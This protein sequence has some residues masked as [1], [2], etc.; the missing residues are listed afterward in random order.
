MA[1]TSSRVRIPH[2][3]PDYTKGLLVLQVHL[4]QIYTHPTM[5]EPPVKRNVIYY[6][7]ADISTF[8][9]IYISFLSMVWLIYKLTDS[10]ADLGIMGLT[11]HGPF[12]FSLFG[13]VIADNF[14][15]RKTVLRFNIAFAI[16]A[17][18]VLITFISGFLSLPLIFIFSF[19]LG[20]ILSIYYPSMIA[21]VRD[22]VTDKKEFPKI[23]GAAATNAKTGQ[24]IASSS[25]SFIIPAFTAAGTFL[26]ALFFNIAS[27]I[28]ISRIKYPDI[29]IQKKDESVL[30]QV[31][32]GLQYVLKHKPLIGI[33]LMMSMTSLAFIFVTFQMPLIDKEFLGGGSSNLGVLFIG[34][35]IGGLTSGIYLGRRKSTKN[36]LWFLVICV[37]FSGISI[38]GL[39][40]SRELWLSFIFAMGVDFSFIAALGMSNTLLQLLSKSEISGRVLG[41]NNMVSLGFFAVITMLLSFLAKSVGMETVMIGIG[42]SLLISV[43][44]YVA[45]L[46]LQRPILNRIYT[47]RDI[48]PEKQPI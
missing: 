21:M 36:L 2:S 45:S 19:L 37:A 29:P 43:I 20:T 23:M 46:K 9:S 13:G 4:S 38:T 33:I 22:I 28:S 12:L 42:I 18:I 6:F 15:R 11:L 27:I 31:K 30:K 47:E 17:A 16:L 39:S 40:L 35:A 41:I 8:T 10:S 24:L 7:I 26:L 5:L 48:T 44:L 3:L 25:F 1:A 34:G 32:T 14:I